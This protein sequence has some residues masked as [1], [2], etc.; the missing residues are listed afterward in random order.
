MRQDDR[1]I[2][3]SATARQPD[4]CLVFPPLVVGSIGSYYPSL[5]VLAS[6]LQQSGRT[7]WQVDLNED[8]AAYLLA[9]GRLSRCAAGD[10]G[11]GVTH[12][13]DSPE[14]IAAR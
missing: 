7:A 11:D 8:F 4:A 3:G 5:A 12:A 10:F 9:G 13:V 1:E 2:T 14:R 6:Y